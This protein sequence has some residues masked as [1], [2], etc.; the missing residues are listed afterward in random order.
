MVNAERSEAAFDMTNVNK[1]LKASSSGISREAFDSMTPSFK[2]QAAFI[3][4]VKDTQM[5][6]HNKEE[7]IRQDLYSDEKAIEV[8]RGDCHGFLIPA[9][10][11][12]ITSPPRSSDVCFV[13]I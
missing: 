1:T 5:Q 9:A 11:S 2:R 3:L 12:I 8:S 7:I 4:D 10:F 13:V 6:G